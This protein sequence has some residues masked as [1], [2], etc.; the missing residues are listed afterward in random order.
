MVAN[1]DVVPLTILFTIVNS[2]VIFIQISG[3]SWILTMFYKD[4][5]TK[6]STFLTVG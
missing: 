4:N 3:E 2:L 1:R 5:K 6:A